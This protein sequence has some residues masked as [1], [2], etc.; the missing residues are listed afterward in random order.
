MSHGNGVA[1]QRDSPQYCSIGP[2][3]HHVLGSM[4]RS[5]AR[6]HARMLGGVASLQRCASGHLGCVLSSLLHSAPCL[7]LLPH[8]SPVSARVTNAYDCLLRQKDTE[9]HRETQRWSTCIWK[10]QTS[11]RPPCSNRGPCL[12]LLLLAAR[13][14]AAR[15]R[16][17]ST[18]CAAGG[19]RHVRVLLLLVLRDT[20]FLLP[21]LLV[22]LPK[23]GGRWLCCHAAAITVLS[24]CSCHA[25][26]LPAGAL[27]GQRRGLACR[28]LGCT[29]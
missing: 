26:T 9:G 4:P 8:G 16:R 18:S 5:M 17:R 7:S 24:T 15:Y 11:L 19:S 1:M 22:C 2:L 14:L 20:L 21:L 25:V 29:T 27:R 6:S 12:L 23:R 28:L 10:L 3:P 13:M